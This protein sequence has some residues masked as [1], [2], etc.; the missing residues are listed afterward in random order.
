MIF[1]VPFND[2]I[3]WGLAIGQ[4][5][6]TVLRGLYEA[7][8]WK[9]FQQWFLNRHGYTAFPLIIHN[10]SLVKALNHVYLYYDPN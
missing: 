1:M 7:L 4:D 8:L 5:V 3:L 10:I 6:K 9:H 2:G